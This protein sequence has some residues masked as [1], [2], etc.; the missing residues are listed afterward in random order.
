MRPFL[1]I[2]DG[3]YEDAAHPFRPIESDPALRL[4]ELERLM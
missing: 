1:R 2:A 4:I 3:E